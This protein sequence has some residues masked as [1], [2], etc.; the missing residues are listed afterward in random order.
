MSV[1]HPHLLHLGLSCKDLTGGDLIAYLREA[2]PYYRSLAGV[3]LRLFRHAEHAGQFIEVLEYQ[4]AATF[5]SDQARVAGDDEMKR[6]LAL[7]RELLVRP[8]TVDHYIDITGDIFP[9]S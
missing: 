1:S 3:D 6:F 9:R 5:H 4:T 7:W 8:P 2:L